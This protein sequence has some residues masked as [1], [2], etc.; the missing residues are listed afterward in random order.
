MNESNESE[1]ISMKKKIMAMLAAISMMTAAVPAM[2]M[3]VSAA[4]GGNFCVISIDY[5]EDGATAES[6]GET[7]MTV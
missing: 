6:S 2:A 1:V 5:A 7:T 4:Y 3:P